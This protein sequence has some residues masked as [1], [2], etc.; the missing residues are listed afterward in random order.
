MEG[1]WKK[2]GATLEEVGKEITKARNFNKKL[3][4]GEEVFRGEIGVYGN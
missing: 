2:K 3:S 1:W 4:W